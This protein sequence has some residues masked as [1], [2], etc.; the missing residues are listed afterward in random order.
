MLL[1]NY[2]EEQ[3][4]NLTEIIKDSVRENKY[5]IS[6]EENKN[7]NIQ[8]IEEYNITENKLIDI[9]FNLEY[10]D[11]CYGI[12]NMKDGI[13]LEDLYVFCPKNELHDINGMKVIVDIYIKLYI[14]EITP[15]EYRIIISLHE[16]NKP[17]TYLFKE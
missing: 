5:T 17:I 15:N 7:E 12:Q 13:E 3:I 4:K 6:L 2:T 16:R 11:F 8:F 1:K 10:T 9:L 14:L